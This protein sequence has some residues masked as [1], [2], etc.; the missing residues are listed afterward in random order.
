VEKSTEAIAISVNHPRNHL[1]LYKTDSCNHCGVL[2]LA[3]IGEASCTH[4]PL[5][6][7]NEYAIHEVLQY[8]DV[9]KYD[10]KA[11]VR[12]TSIAEP[13]DGDYYKQV[14]KWFTHRKLYA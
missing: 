8:R 4:S 9:A 3:K 2:L 7:P 6:G 10:D 11:T 12:T 5:C 14:M 13:S 1:S